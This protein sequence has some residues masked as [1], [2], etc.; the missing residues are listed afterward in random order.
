M[1]KNGEPRMNAEPSESR[2]TSAYD[3]LL[4]YDVPSVKKQQ[5]TEAHDI[6]EG[7]YDKKPAQSSTGAAYNLG[8]YAYKTA[9]APE[10]PS[11]D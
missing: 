8:S 4:N 3:V 7:A 9:K 1:N 11:L 2:S 10:T 5:T 6:V